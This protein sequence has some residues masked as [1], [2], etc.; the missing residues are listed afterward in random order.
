MPNTGGELF[1]H[2]LTQYGEHTTQPPGHAFIQPFDGDGMKWT[3]GGCLMYGWHSNWSDSNGQSLCIRM[4]A[5]AASAFRQ[6][7]STT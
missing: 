4:I 2:C 6:T 3:G 1:S 7:L 5:R